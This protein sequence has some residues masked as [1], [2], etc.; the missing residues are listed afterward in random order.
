MVNGNARLSGKTQRPEYPGAFV[1]TLRGRTVLSVA[2]WVLYCARSSELDQL[3]AN[4]T[5]RAI[6]APLPSGHSPGDVEP[7]HRLLI[8]GLELRL[9]EH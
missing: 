8:H 6:P 9:A 3:L 7:W 1:P 2:Y 5:R 4:S